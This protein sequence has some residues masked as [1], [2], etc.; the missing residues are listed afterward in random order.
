[1]RPDKI[2][3]IQQE[4]IKTCREELTVD[5]VIKNERIVIVETILYQLL[6]FD[7]PTQPRLPAPSAVSLHYHDFI[8]LSANITATWLLRL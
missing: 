3:N 6:L 2:G 5:E 7:V 1:M 4:E 8:A